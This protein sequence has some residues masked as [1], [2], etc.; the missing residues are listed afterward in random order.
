MISQTMIHIVNI[1]RKCLSFYPYTLYSLI[2][3]QKYYHYQKIHLTERSFIDT[4]TI[5]TSTTKKMSENLETQFVSNKIV[6]TSTGILSNDIDHWLRWSVLTFSG[7]V[8]NESND[9]IDHW[10][11]WS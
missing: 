11:R 9:Q 5:T 1:I 4:L 10:L 6:V 8:S 2:Q 3:F 7:K